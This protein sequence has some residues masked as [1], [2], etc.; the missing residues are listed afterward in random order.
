MTLTR[1][2]FIRKAGAAAALGG[3]AA[4][5]TAEKAAAHDNRSAQFDALGV[6]TPPLAAG[7]QIAGS[8]DGALASVQQQ[9]TGGH[10]LAV[11][12]AAAGGPSQSALNAVSKNP[13]SSAAQVTGCETAHGTV[14]IA[15]VGYA[16]GSD[17]NAAA[18][19]IDLKTGS[20]TGTRAQG[21]YITSTTDAAPGGNALN[22]RYNRLDW[23]VVKGGNSGAG[24]GVVGIGVPIGHIPSGMLEID[25]KDAG[26]PALYLRAP[27][28]GPGMSLYLD[29]SGNLMARTAAGSVRTVVAV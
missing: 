13:A 24:Q 20:G 27:G 3:A 22:I 1:R 12:L 7:V 23:F 9:G 2:W 25:Q 8:L 14:K 5:L 17:A 19:S 21:V 28:G 11:V 18:L 16:D 26:T 10:A 6:G 15:H 29:P 4:A